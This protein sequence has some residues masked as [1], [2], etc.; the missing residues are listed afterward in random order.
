MIIFTSASIE[1]INSQTNLSQGD[2]ERLQ[3]ALGQAL[4]DAAEETLNAFGIEQDSTP[5]IILSDFY[6]S[7]PESEAAEGDDDL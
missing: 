7:D 5:T 4:E 2:L 1:I 6:Q 3:L